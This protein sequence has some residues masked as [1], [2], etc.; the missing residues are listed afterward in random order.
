[1]SKMTGI[2]SRPVTDDETCTSDLCYCAAEKLLASLQIPRESIDALIFISQT[3]DF[4]LPPTSHILHERLGLATDAA[5]FDV[6]LGCSGYTYGLW[7]A[8]SLL[9]GQ[10]SRV[11]LLVGDTCSKFT[12][13]QDRSTFPL[14]GDAA[15]ATIVEKNNAAG[16]A[17][18]VMGSDGAGAQNLIIKAG[19]FRDPRRGQALQRIEGAD[20]NSRRDDELFM[21]GQEVFTFTLNTVSPLV[22][23]LL[24]YSQNSIETVDQ[25][26]FHQANE[27]MLKHLAKKAG[28][29]DEKMPLT[30]KNF[31]NTSS[32]SI[33]L[34]ICQKLKDKFTNEKPK[35]A[36]FGFGVGLSWGAA[37]IHSPIELIDSIEFPGT[38][39]QQ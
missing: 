30:M 34:T 28:I 15:A 35:L 38:G 8:S 6:N 2:Q 12:S 1:M 5:V 21:N 17:H 3:P 19:G 9:Q 11:L 20:G 7:L 13:D 26:V 4:I 32:A 27:F 29:P 16:P 18:F 10:I 37:L 36:M 31:G 22:N 14:F 33:P 39:D 23:S 25:F 24:E